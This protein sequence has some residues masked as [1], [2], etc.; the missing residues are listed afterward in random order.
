MVFIDDDKFDNDTQKT[1]P[2]MPHYTTRLVLS[3]SHS[4]T[5][6]NIFEKMSKA[7]PGKL[8]RGSTDPLPNHYG[9]IKEEQNMSDEQLLQD[10]SISDSFSTVPITVHFSVSVT[11][12]TRDSK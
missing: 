9:F 2:T 11:A 6:T 10:L 12:F 7:R 8:D 1:E 4:E 3:E 5:A